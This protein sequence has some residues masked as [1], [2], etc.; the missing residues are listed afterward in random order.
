M[1]SILYI[2]CETTSHQLHGPATTP[3]SVCRRQSSESDS[4]SANQTT[5]TL[6]VR[7][8]VMQNSCIISSISDISN[9]WIRVHC[10]SPS[11]TGSIAPSLRIPVPTTFTINTMSTQNLFMWIRSILA[12][13]GRR[14]CRRKNGVCFIYDFYFYFE[15]NWIF[16]LKFYFAFCEVS[17]DYVAILRNLTTKIFCAV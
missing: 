17:S 2:M 9:M 11:A 13:T 14:W 12:T 15:L 3:H 16:G 6:S 8:S 5:S 10:G 7:N 4:H 1:Q